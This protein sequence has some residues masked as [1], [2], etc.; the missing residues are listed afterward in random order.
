VE[1]LEYEDYLRRTQ[2]DWESR[3]ENV[4]ELITF[5]SEVEGSSLDE[6]DSEE[7]PTEDEPKE[8]PLRLFLQ[9]SML[10]SEGDSQSEDNNKERVTIS[11]CHAAKGLEWP[12]VMVPAVEDGTFPFYRTEDIEEERR[13]LY[14]ACT[15]A[16]GLLY[17]SHAAVRKVAGETKTKKLSE[18][19]SVIT[20]QTPGL[21]TG[22][23]PDFQ[24][25]DRAVI[26]KVLNRPLPDEGEVS[27][28]I[29]EF[30]RTSRHYATDSNEQ[31]GRVSWSG[32]GANPQHVV[33]AQNVSTSFTT[34]LDLARSPTPL[35]IH[36]RSPIVP[37][38][39]FSQPQH[40]QT[41]PSLGNQVVSFN[42]LPC[43]KFSDT[44]PPKTEYDNENL[45]PAKPTASA[46]ANSQANIGQTV[47]Q[48][49]KRR[50]GMG[51]GGVGY[52]NKKFKPPT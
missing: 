9:A 30:I 24:C 7:T 33:T 35:S 45:Q 19:V 31:D 3:W 51:R 22:R 43:T 37:A 36:A 2:P 48:G 41:A 5:A 15:R 42:V 20:T 4:Q 40:R 39:I 44:S 34:V 25:D 52:S 12:V 50:L 18:F 32:S 23:N 6:L 28:R 49:V 13:L 27:R 8:T 38:V 14:V 17:L 47:T 10:S 26:C 21:F 29:A 16:Q 11:T 1:L 46:Q